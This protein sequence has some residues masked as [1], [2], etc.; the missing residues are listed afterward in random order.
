[1][2]I[3]A[4]LAKSRHGVYYYRFQFIVAAKRK[5]QRF[6]LATK[7]PRTAKAKAIQ[8][9]AII[10][11]KKYEG[12]IMTFE[13]DDTDDIL[14]RLR[15]FD[16]VLPNGMQINNIN[17][18]EDINGV[19]SMLS[20]LEKIN[21]SNQP[22]ST[23]KPTVVPIARQHLTQ[24][25]S[26]PVEP[27][28]GMTL[29]EIIARFATR[30]REK[31]TEKTAYEYRKSQEKFAFWIETRKNNQNYPIHLIGKQDIADFIDDLKN[32]QI[33]DRTIQH[34][35]LAAIAG[36]FDLAIKSGGYPS[37]Q[38]P[39]RGHKVFTHKDERKL[40]SKTQYKPFIEAELKKIFDPENLKA[41]EKPADYWLPLLGLYTGGRI[42][43]LCQLAITDIICQDG[44]WAISINDEDYKSIK[45]EAARR[46][47]PLHPQLLA[48]GF[49]EYVSDA[50]QHGT[51]L[52]PY[53]NADKFGKFSNTPGKRFADYLDTLGISDTQKVF[54]SLRK[55]SN[56]TLKQNGV[57]E[58]TRCQYVGHE[59]ESTNSTDYG[60]KHSLEYL[61]QTVSPKL[62]FD[63][64]DVEKLRH[65]NGHFFAR[66][67][68]L[69][70]R[71]QRLINHKKVV[72]SK[73]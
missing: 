72:A 40:K 20:I 46:I 58:E 26:A 59:Y 25:I 23:Y 8:I 35:Y 41:K 29:H 27:V 42:E 73:K 66:L 13:P 47:V 55:T 54:H 10:A 15:L 28:G 19:A 36:L 31:L 6:S 21:S 67:K 14:D 71:T 22:S 2:K 57:P 49:L 16:V 60:E 56:N 39:A 37:E 18:Q 52:F 38:N 11:Q 45:T 1:M 61:A 7:C 3:P 24:Q 53:L 4:N 12:S 44:I 33:S 30:Q 62:T 65:P 34:K 5:E 68:H 51:M 43:E 64:I 48:L 9:S 32:K 17:T 70:K 63:F 69:S 50:K